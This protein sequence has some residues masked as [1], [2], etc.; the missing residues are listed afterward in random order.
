MN[1]KQ[2]T[3][4]W[5]RISVLFVLLLVNFM[6]AWAQ[7]ARKEQI[8]LKLRNAS[9]SEVLQAIDQQSKFSVV[10]ADDISKNSKKVNFNEPNISVENALKKLQAE[11]GVDYLVSGQVISVKKGSA[12]AQATKSESISGRVTDESG[13]PLP[14]TT[15]ML[16]DTYIAT[17]T[18][19]DG[20]YRFESIPPVGIL[21][22]TFVGMETKEVAFE[23]QSVIHV[24]MLTDQQLV[25]EVVV[26]ALGLTREEKSLGYAVTKVNNEEITRSVSGNWM[27]GLEG[28]V[29]GLTFDKAGGTPGGS[30][31]VTLRGD[32]SLNYGNNEALFVV[33]GIPISSGGTST[34]SGANYSTNDQPVD[35]G[36]GAGELNPDD[37]ESVSVLKGPAAAALYG[38]RAANGAIIITTKSSKMKKKGIGVSINSSV[39]FE[40]AGYFPD[41]QSTYGPG[42]E[43]GAVAYSAWNVSAE[44]APDGV[45]KSR[46]QSTYAFGE[47][48]DANEMR[49]LYASYDWENG[50]FTKLPW[51]YADDWYTGLFETGVTTSN[52]ISVDGNNGEGTNTRLS[53]TDYRNNWIMPNSGFNQN[54]V[55]LTFNTKMNDYIDVKAKVNYSKKT[56]DNMP[57]SGYSRNNPMYTLTWG[58]SSNSMDQWKSEWQNGRYNAKYTTADNEL[59]QIALVDPR[60]DSSNPYVTLYENLNTQ[61]KDRVFGSLAVTAHLAKNLAL[62]VRSGIDWADDFRTQRRPYLSNGYEKGFYREQ[63]VRTMEMNSDF[64]LRYNNDTWL[65]ERLTFAA[66]IGGNN[67]T[68]KYFNNKTTLNNLGEEGVYNLSNVVAGETPTLYNY[69]SQ[70]VVNSMYGMISLGWND[71]YYV[72]ITGRNDWSS[73]LSKGNWSYFYPSVAASILVDKALDLQSSIRWMDMLKVRLSWA[74]V[75]NDTSPY[76][77]DQLY[78]ASGTYSGSYSLPSSIPDPNI[79]PENV[80]SWEA[81]LETRLFQNRIRVDLAVYSSSTTNQIYSAAVDQIVGARTMTI[82]A[83]EIANKGV[84]VALGF[85][86]VKTKDFKWDFDITWSKNKNTLV[87]VSDEWDN[88]EPLQTSM[89]TTIGSRTFVYS[90]VGEEMHKIYGKGIQRAPEG[91]T[92]TTAS[93][94]TKSAAGMHIVDASNG[95]PLLDETTTTEI[96]NVNPDWRAGMTHRLRYK[97]LSLAATFTGQLGG[98]AFSVTNFALSYIGKLNNSIEG[99]NDGLVHHG[100][101]LNADGTYTENTTVTSSIQTYYNAYIWNRDNTEMNT[102]STSFLKLKEVRMDYDLPKTLCAKTGIVQGAAVGVYA[103]NVFCLTEFPQYDP[104]VGMLN[105]SNIMKGIETMSMPMTR[106]IGFNV[107]LSF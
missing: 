91:A 50:T 25:D 52:T 61:D 26:T 107:K 28:K 30:M 46:N 49:Y 69:R 45:A 55:A 85:T 35:Y 53:F 37:I 39:T 10:Y 83:G 9:V 94:E 79:K 21:V 44:Q 80:E 15:V 90:Y 13:L 86:P 20:N 68:N 56:S 104:E 77:L 34:T 11:T 54:T 95:Y 36:N 99:R 5:R 97:N 67:M 105:G 66:M 23:N 1:F 17:T 16:K 19:I 12:K 96:G 40:K 64:L 87:S 48:Y 31:R 38:S 58:Q 3:S 7:D 27:T 92:Y 103:T 65:D 2:M 33:D 62:D 14:G 73:T 101:N 100:V 78:S 41:F 4:R 43:L 93:G 76:S 71:T 106:T 47:K 84:E 32:N 75:G 72:D 29:A 102:F 60:A 89:G 8:S 24:R 81:G 82:N 74:N 57:T 18:D 63:T 88:N 42:N 22:F 6:P 51:Q 98:N 59:G 70:K